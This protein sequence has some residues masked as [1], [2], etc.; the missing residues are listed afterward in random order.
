MAGYVVLVHDIDRSQNRLGAEYYCIYS[1]L[2]D[3]RLVDSEEDEFVSELASKGQAA[4]GLQGS[5]PFEKELI[6]NRL[7]DVFAGTVQVRL[8]KIHA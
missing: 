8:R 6:T 1:N 7:K 3:G 2:A 5:Q 4:T